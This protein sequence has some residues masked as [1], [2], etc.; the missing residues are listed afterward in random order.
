VL[1]NQLPCRYAPPFLLLSILS[2]FCLRTTC[3]DIVVLPIVN[4]QLP[5]LF[6]SLEWS[7]AGVC[8]VSICQTFFFSAGLILCVPLASTHY[9]QIQLLLILMSKSGTRCD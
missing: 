6:F 3:N 7:L 5:K 8:P 1:E 4:L 2:C 9:E